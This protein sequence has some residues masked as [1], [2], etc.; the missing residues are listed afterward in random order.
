[1]REL[2]PEVS[3]VVP[4]YNV[5]KHLARCLESV[6]AQSRGDW[7]LLCVNDASP[8]NCSG[9]LQDYAARDAR[10]RVLNRA[11]NGGLAAARNTGLEQARGRYILFLDADDS[12]HPRLLEYTLKAAEENDAQ[13]V[14]FDYERVAEDFLLPDEAMELDTRLRVVDAPLR[15]RRKRG[16][17][18]IHGSACTMLCRRELLEGLRFE[19][20]LFEDYPYT[21]RVLQRR[22]RTV[23]LRAALYYYSSNRD[24]IM[25]REFCPEHIEDYRKGLE[26]V[27]ALCQIAAPDEKEHMIHEIFPDILKQ[28]YNR[29]RRSS[30]D[31]Q[32]ALWKTFAAT[33]RALQDLGCLQFRGHKLS[34][35][36]RY[37][38][39]MNQY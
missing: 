9:I 10:V 18:L 26:D 38:H 35:W 22:P 15:Y 19:P 27:W 36:L 25:Q 28:I 4:I 29:I 7:E 20:I 2:Q 21:L 17:W 34:R 6:L 3:I 1:M 24:S 37:R 12:I 13:L 23:I 32:P 8:D 30:A 11:E 33:L 16:R 31:K 14:C 39:I 5:E